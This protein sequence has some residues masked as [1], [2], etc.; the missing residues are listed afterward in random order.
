MGSFLEEVTVNPAG[1][2]GI[3]GSGPGVRGE[4][5]AFGVE[6]K[7]VQGIRE[8][9]EGCAVGGLH[10]GRELRRWAGLGAGAGGLQETGQVQRVSSGVILLDLSF[11]KPRGSRGEN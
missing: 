11:E 10:L 5:R 3:R 9:G 7:H 1:S 6:E 2:R 4:G 8:A